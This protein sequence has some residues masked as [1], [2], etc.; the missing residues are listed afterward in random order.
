MSERVEYLLY[1]A[2]ATVPEFAVALFGVVTLALCVDSFRIAHQDRAI[3][4]RN[5]GDPFAFREAASQIRSSFGRGAIAFIFLF[6]GVVFLRTPPRIPPSFPSLIAFALLT[7][8]ILIL[9]ALQVFDRRD[10]RENIRDL[11]ALRRAR[12][13]SAAGIIVIDQH[14]VILQFNAAAERIFGYGADEVIGASMTRLIPERFRADHLRGMARATASDVPG[15]RMNQILDL[16]GL[17]KGGTEAALHITLSETKG[18]TGKVFVAIFTE[19]IPGAD[20]LTR[21]PDE[22]R[23]DTQMTELVHNTEIS[24]EARD[25]ALDA[26]HT[27]NNMNEKLL[28]VQQEIAETNRA[29]GRSADALRAL[30]EEQESGRSNRQDEREVRQ[31]ARDVQQDKRD[32]QTGEGC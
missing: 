18:V 28:R 21:N 14:S 31:D 25:G 1:F 6:L 5:G 9:L 7:A 12:E 17:R 24:T 20:K 11:L 30:L 26:Y 16:P 8:V 19:E 10:R 13:S 32:E 3:L 23:H 29:A 27:A 22:L 15:P 2:T 4:R